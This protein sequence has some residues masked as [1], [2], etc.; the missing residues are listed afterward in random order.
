MNFFHH[1]DLGNHLLQL[2]PK[3]V[4]HPVRRRESVSRCRATGCCASVFR[5]FQKKSFA[6]FQIIRL[7]LH[8]LFLCLNVVRAKDLIQKLHLLCVVGTSDILYVFHVFLAK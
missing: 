5:Q 2:C 7:Q 8:L 6:R 1:K 4:K 3:V